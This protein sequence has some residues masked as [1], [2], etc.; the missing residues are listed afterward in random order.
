[1]VQ[2]QCRECGTYNR[3]LDLRETKGV[4]E[5]S[6][7]GM[8]NRLVGWRDNCFPVVIMDGGIEICSRSHKR[9]LTDLYL[10]Q[11]QEKG[12]RSYPY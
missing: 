3:N 5:C 7:C 10:L 8:L 9:K 12:R 11:R 2:L 1:M 4:F 6:A